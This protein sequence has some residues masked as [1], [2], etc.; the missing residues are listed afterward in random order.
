MIKKVI[1]NLVYIKHDESLAI[2]FPEQELPLG[3]ENH[4]PHPYHLLVIG[5]DL[6]QAHRLLDLEVVASPEATIFFLPRCP[7]RHSYI[8]TIKGLTY[9]DTSG[10]RELV[11]EL[12][13]KTF[14]TSP[15][16]RAIIENHANL[17]SDKAVN[18]I[19]NVRAAFLPIKQCMNTIQCWNIYFQNDPN[20]DEETYKLLHRKM[21]ACTFKT[22]TFGKG[23]A[24]TGENEQPLCTGCK[25]TDHDLFN[26]PFL[27]LPG[28][29]RYCPVGPGD[30]AG[31]T[32]FADEDK[33]N[34]YHNTPNG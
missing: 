9:N 11:E 31:T 21:R 29:L 5:L 14:C 15:E 28:W 4:Y 22:L 20:L 16:I 13:K 26:C 2:I 8:L 24:L 12:A 33:Y 30:I 23:Y 27:R 10:A 19:L 3:G 34:C 32:D 7:P 17:S 1:K 6:Q 18:D 25:F